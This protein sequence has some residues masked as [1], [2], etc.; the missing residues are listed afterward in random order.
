M[1]CM[2]SERECKLRLAFKK[3]N[4]N[5]SSVGKAPH[6][7]RDLYSLRLDIETPLAIMEETGILYTLP[8]GAKFMYFQTT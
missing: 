2:G 3:Q 7:Q 8:S 1:G 4:R 5:A 6:V